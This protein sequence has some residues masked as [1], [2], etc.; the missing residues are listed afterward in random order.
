MAAGG[1]ANVPM[2]E[3]LK[4]YMSDSTA[5]SNAPEKK[6]R[7]KKS[8]LKLKKVDNVVIRDTDVDWTAP[9]DND[10][11]VSHVTS[12]RSYPPCPFDSPPCLHS[13]SVR[14]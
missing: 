6:R 4:R 7:R 5:S 14:L 13:G 12:A 2:S 9:V 8:G 10:D 1:K 3:Y 11:D